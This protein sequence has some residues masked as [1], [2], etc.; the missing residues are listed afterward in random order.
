MAGCEMGR[1]AVLRQGRFLCTADIGGVPAARREPAAGRRRDRAGHIALQHDLLPLE[2]GVRVGHGHS[3]QQRLRVRVHR[4]LVQFLG[5]RQL[6]DLPQVH[7]RDPVRHVPDHAEVV[8]DENVGE[9]QGVLKVI[10]QVDHLRPDGH[11][12][13]GDRLVRDDQPGMQRERAR[14]AYSLPLA[15]G[16]LVRIAVGMLRRQPHQV[17]Q[18]AHP[19][20][21]RRTVALAVDAQRLGDDVADP[22]ARVE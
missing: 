12:K 13:R 17:H 3:R 18:L 1:A 7:D 20:P 10:K 8:C 22:F 2:R 11:V 9:P 19:P 14:H 16:E 6:H 21:D 5:R 15:A 4:P